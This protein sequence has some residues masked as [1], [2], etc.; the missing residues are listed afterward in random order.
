MSLTDH[1]IPEPPRWVDPL[2]AAAVFAYP[3]NDARDPVMTDAELTAE[4]RRIAVELFA[5]SSSDDLARSAAGHLRA[6]ADRLDAIPDAAAEVHAMLAGNY[7]RERDV[8]NLDPDNEVRR[9]IREERLQIFDRLIA[10]AAER[11]GP[12]RDGDIPEGSDD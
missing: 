10:L 6:L 7:E 8:W 3:R 5:R 4:A 12:P 1:D 2:D 9:R 11:G